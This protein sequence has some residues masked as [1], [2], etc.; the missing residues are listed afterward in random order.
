MKIKKAKKSFKKAIRWTKENGKTVVSV[1]VVLALLLAC[2]STLISKKGSQH[3]VYGRMITLTPLYDEPVMK[4]SYSKIAYASLGLD[5][6][7]ND[8]TV[9]GADVG[10]YSDSKDLTTQEQK[11]KAALEALLAENTRQAIVA[12][13]EKRNDEYQVNELYEIGDTNVTVIVTSNGTTATTSTE[14]NSAVGTAEYTSS[15]GTYQG[16]F[17]LTGYCPCAICCGKTNGITASGTLATS[18]HTIAADSRYSF[19]TKL[20]INGQVYTVE[21]RGGAI[22][23][24]HIDVFFNTHQEALNFGKQYADVYLYDG[25]NGTEASTDSSD[26]S[27]SSESE[28]SS[29]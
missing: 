9:I 27:D 29:E 11:D 24:N 21:D 20:V 10:A 12:N 28:E 1:V 4:A 3:D 16:L 8:Q 19:G 26:S 13:A 2:V 7:S 17:L 6:V 22:T 18:N 5:V 25:T 14:G 23:G 15:T